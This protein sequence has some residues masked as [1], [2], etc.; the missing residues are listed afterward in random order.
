MLYCQKTS[1][2]L[3]R[4]KPRIDDRLAQKAE[5]TWS[6]WT[7]SDV[8]WKRKIVGWANSAMEQISYEEWS[9]KTIPAKH[10]HLRRTAEKQHVS[11]KEIEKHSLDTENIIVEYPGTMMTSAQAMDRLKGLSKK[12][13]RYHNRYFWLSAIGAPLTLPMA[14]LP[15]IPNLPGFYLLFRAWSHWKAL[16]GAKHL[17]YL[18]ED[19]HLSLQ[20]NIRLNKLFL[21]HEKSS[22]TASLTG[23]EIDDLAEELEASEM[24]SELHRAF[25]QVQK[26]K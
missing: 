9:L 20:D 8:K 15:V 11:V 16:E 13:Q 23:N 1:L 14:A 4:S 10:A 18:V 17:S 24:A 21:E 26:P 25:K 22:G 12:G 5:K 19:N 2:P 6:A 3:A 7:K